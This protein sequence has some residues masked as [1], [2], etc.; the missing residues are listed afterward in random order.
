MF[1]QPGEWSKELCCGRL[2]LVAAGGIACP[3]LSSRAGPS[4]IS[5]RSTALTRLHALTRQGDAFPLPLPDQ[6]PFELS[7]GSITES[8]RLAIGGAPPGEDQTHFN[9]RHPH[10]L[11]VRVW[12]SERSLEV[13]KHRSSS[14]SLCGHPLV[15]APVLPLGEQ[16]DVAID[17]NVVDPGRDQSAGVC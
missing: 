2:S 15:Q 3:I 16:S 8:M 6:G 11:R 1:R 13:N 17:W 14:K 4:R 5:E 10:P 12:T 9:E 7:E